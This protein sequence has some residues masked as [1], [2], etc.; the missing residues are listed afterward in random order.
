MT[1]L[2]DKLFFPRSSESGYWPV[3][4]FAGARSR[5]QSFRANTKLSFKAGN[6]P[7]SISLRIETVGARPSFPVAWRVWADLIVD[8]D[9]FTFRTNFVLLH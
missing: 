4:L 1:D 7:S 3:S 2:N 5:C 6:W 8:F 9:M